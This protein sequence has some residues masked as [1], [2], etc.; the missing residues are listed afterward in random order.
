[1]LNVRQEVGIAH[2]GLLELI[3]LAQ[4]AS[5]QIACRYLTQEREPK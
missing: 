3:D 2:Q 5:V 1:M 4:H